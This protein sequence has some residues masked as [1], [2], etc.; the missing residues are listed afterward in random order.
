MANWH[1]HLLRKCQ[2]LGQDMMDTQDGERHPMWA[3]IIQH[4]TV[5]TPQT[6]THPPSFPLHGPT[7]HNCCNMRKQCVPQ[8]P[9]SPVPNL[10][11][12]GIIFSMPVDAG[13]LPQPCILRSG[14]RCHCWVPIVS[15]QIFI[16]TINLILCSPMSGGWWIMPEGIIGYNKWHCQVWECWCGLILPN[17]PSFLQ[18]IRSK[19]GTYGECEE[20]GLKGMSPISKLPLLLTYYALVL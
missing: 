4:D 7:M 20:C 12:W 6:S 14:T 5:Y 11:L 18:M 15:S 10:V 9:S 8:V 3:A 19:Y 16:P 2:D 13:H 17:M 1:F